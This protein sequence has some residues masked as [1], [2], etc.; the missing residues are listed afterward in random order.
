MDYVRLKRTGC[1][2]NKINIF[3]PR[4]NVKQ[5]VNSRYV[6]KNSGEQWYACCRACKHKRMM[7]AKST[8]KIPVGINGTG[9]C[10]LDRNRRTRR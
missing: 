6:S 9:N 7:L 1:V 5:R 10:N 3:F 8:A 4:G 2:N